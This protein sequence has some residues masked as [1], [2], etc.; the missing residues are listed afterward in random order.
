MFAAGPRIDARTVGLDTSLPADLTACLHVPALSL[1]M[2]SCIEARPAA[3]TGRL[4]IHYGLSETDTPYGRP[5]RSPL[6]LAPSYPPGEHP[7]DKKRLTRYYCTEY[8]W[9]EYSGWYV[10]RVAAR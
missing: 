5:S 3:V 9:Y 8:L 2:S 10:L 7:H 6:D 4:V 1:A